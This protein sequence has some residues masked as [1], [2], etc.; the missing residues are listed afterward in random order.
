MLF[1]IISFWDI[2]K[3]KSRLVV[4]ESLGR[5]LLPFSTTDNHNVTDYLTLTVPFLQFFH[6]S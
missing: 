4:Q 6:F 5:S 1:S 3:D 2:E